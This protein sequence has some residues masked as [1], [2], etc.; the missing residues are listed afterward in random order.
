MSFAHSAQY[1]QLLLYILIEVVNYILCLKAKIFI[2]NLTI[3]FPLLESEGLAV[4]TSHLPVECIVARQ[5]YVL[6][7]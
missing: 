2:E 7:S 4:G 6:V 5:I 3:Q 1:K